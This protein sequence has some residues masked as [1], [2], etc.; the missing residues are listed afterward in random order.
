MFSSYLMYFPLIFW[1]FGASLLH[2]SF[3]ARD[4]LRVKKILLYIFFGVIINLLCIL[5]IVIPSISIFVYISHTLVDQI[6]VFAVVYIAKNNFFPAMNSRVID[7]YHSS[8]TNVVYLQ[9]QKL[10]RAYR[11]L[12]Y[13][14]VIVF[15]LYV[16]KNMIFYNL[17][18]VLESISLNSCWFHVTYH[19]PILQLSEHT[20]YIL[21]QLSEFMLDIVRLIDLTVY[22]SFIIL[23]VNFIVIVKRFFKKTQYRYQISQHLSY[24]T[25]IRLFLRITSMLRLC[26]IRIIGTLFI[27]PIRPNI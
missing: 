8:I 26:H 15:E 21:S 24:L 7:A 2:L 25:T 17:Y 19:L 13:L 14:F 22:C 18:V 9:I 1:L 20:K 27:S 5:P 4:E 11:T 16:L 6:N 12:I 3:A 23:N 10:Y